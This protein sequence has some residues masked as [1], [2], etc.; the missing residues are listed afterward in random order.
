MLNEKEASL[1]YTTLDVI[2]ELENM[3]ELEDIEELSEAEQLE[4]L[5]LLQDDFDNNETINV[6]A[7]E[8]L[9]NNITTVVDQR[10][11]AA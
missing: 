2:N 9:A 1:V 3:V 11:Q 4:V 5:S 10:K 8:W 6:I 7:H